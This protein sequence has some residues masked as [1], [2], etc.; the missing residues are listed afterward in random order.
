VE[1]PTRRVCLIPNHCRSPV[2]SALEASEGT[3][4]AT[5]ASV[6][7]IVAHFS[8]FSAN[9]DD[10]NFDEAISAEYSA[11]VC[12][13]EI[14]CPIDIRQALLDDGKSAEDIALEYDLPVPY[15]RIAC[16]APHM[17]MVRRLIPAG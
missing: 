13:I 3:Y 5:E 7:A 14:L 8:L 15:L 11:E 4:T 12:A 1:P 6:D 17:K 9:A 2:R 10:E 16:R